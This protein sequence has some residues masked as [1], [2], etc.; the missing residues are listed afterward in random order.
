VEL[1]GGRLRREGET[2]AQD[3]SLVADARLDPFDPSQVEGLAALRLVS[4]HWQLGGAVASLG[5]LRPY[6]EKASWLDLDGSGSLDADLRVDRGRLL[7]GSRLSVDPAL[8]RAE[9]L[10]SR[11]S[12]VAELNALVEQ[13]PDGERLSVRVHFDR[14]DIRARDRPEEKTHVTGRGLR[15]SLVTRDLDLARAAKDLRVRLDLPGADVVDLTFYNGYL[16]PGSGVEILSGTGRLRSWLEME[17]AGQTGRG[18]VVLQS[19]AVRV[20]LYDVELEGALSLTAP[21]ASP[22]LKGLRFGLDGTRLDL[23]RVSLREIGSR[24][25]R[26]RATPPGWWARL[27]L[28]RTSMEWGRPMSLAGSVD[29][30][31]RDSDLLLSLFSRRKPYLRWFRRALH[32]EDLAVRGDLRLDQGSVVLDRLVATG[33]GLELRSRLRLSRNNPR[34]YLFL[35]RGSLAVGVELR[36]GRRHYRFRRPARWFESR[37]AP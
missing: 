31:M 17:T 15:L 35:R 6:L 10:L 23:E 18:E 4:G 3:M 12:G 19:E 30:A 13:G 37:G 36:D 32:F 5:F 26:S 1:A 16:P 8:L 24:G 2:V 29:L 11:A 21:L 14:F 27:E 25:E 34:G 33:R 7:P 20:R 9:Y 28:S 22:D